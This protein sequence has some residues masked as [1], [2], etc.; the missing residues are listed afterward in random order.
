MSIFTNSA[1]NAGCDILGAVGVARKQTAKLSKSSSDA[2]ARHKAAANKIIASGQKLA[3]HRPKLGQAF[4][5]YGK[6]ALGRID[7]SVKRSR[8]AA[9]TAAA[10]RAKKQAAI[11]DAA[12]TRVAP[13]LPA[14]ADTLAPKAA[15][16][17]FTDL[18]PKTSPKVF[19]DV[20][21][22][23]STASAITSAPRA[24]IAPR[25]IRSRGAATAA[26]TQRISG[27]YEAGMDA[28]AGDYGFVVPKGIAVG[29]PTGTR[30]GPELQ[31]V[32]AVYNPD[33][34]NEQDLNDIAAMVDTSNTMYPS[35][36]LLMGR[37]GGPA[38]FMDMAVERVGTPEYKLADRGEKILGD[39]RALIDANAAALEAAGFP[40]AEGG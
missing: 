27:A 30:P 25:T 26:A 22:R 20:A 23:S 1:Y 9:Q 21:P 34:L 17:V 5:R 6:A 35:I 37:S 33:T 24:T 40:P 13:K 39:M 10:A 16:K 38:I 19:T 36:D 7:R 8:A 18:A 32:A 2:M 15:P 11:M 4:I 12:T 28:L 29:P 14:G 31:D 3:A